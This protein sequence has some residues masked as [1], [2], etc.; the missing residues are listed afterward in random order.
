MTELPVDPTLSQLSSS[1]YRAIRHAHMLLHYTQVSIIISISKEESHFEHKSCHCYSNRAFR[2][3]LH[4]SHLT[5]LHHA[6]TLG[7]T[8]WGSGTGVGAVWEGQLVGGAI[9]GRGS[10]TG[11]LGSAASSRSDFELRPRSGLIQTATRSSLGSRGQRW[12]SHLPKQTN[13]TRS[14]LSSPYMATMHAH[15][16]TL[17]T[18]VII[19]ISKEKSPFLKTQ[20][21]TRMTHTN[22]IS[23]IYM[24]WASNI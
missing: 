8:P 20:S 19:S 7:E 17:Y 6:R 13:C 1:P 9:G 16:A 15:V 23:G 22:S 4:L 11:V 12:P 18:S 24:L 2:W 14:K 21:M 3:S 10:R 5:S